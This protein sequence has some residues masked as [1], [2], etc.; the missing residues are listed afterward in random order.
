MKVSIRQRLGAMLAAAVVLMES[1]FAK[2]TGVKPMAR[3]VA[4]AH[5]GVEPQLMGLGP[6]PKNKKRA[7][8][9]PPSLIHGFLVYVISIIFMSFMCLPLPY[10]SKT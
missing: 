3:L 2:K 9:R 10:S 1:G 4:Y 7:A 6:G 8:R 5:A